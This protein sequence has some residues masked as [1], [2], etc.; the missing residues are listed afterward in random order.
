MQGYNTAFVAHHVHVKVLTNNWVRNIICSSQWCLPAKSS[1]A[2]SVKACT[3]HT[4][5]S[6]NC[7]CD[8][9]VMILQDCCLVGTLQYS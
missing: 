5:E 6:D 1:T 4:V 2:L 3:A 8:N 9:L 7:C